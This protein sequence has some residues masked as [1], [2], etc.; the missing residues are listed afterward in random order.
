MRLHGR[1][2]R[3]LPTGTCCAC[4]TSTKPIAGAGCGLDRGGRCVWFAGG[5]GDH[6]T[7]YALHPVDRAEVEATPGVPLDRPLFAVDRVARL[8]ARD[9]A[10]GRSGPIAGAT[11]G[12]PRAA[13]SRPTV[14]HRRR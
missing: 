12:V 11:H 14:R 2:A 7:R 10:P 6:A 3:S 13:A 4:P 8:V 5:T 9:R 1:P